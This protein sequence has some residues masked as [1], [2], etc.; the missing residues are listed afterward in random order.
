MHEHLA[1]A[2]LEM[3]FFV[4]RKSFKYVDTLFRQLVSPISRLSYPYEDDWRPP[5]L[6]LF[7]QTVP[8]FC[9]RRAGGTLDVSLLS[10][11]MIKL[12]ALVFSVCLS[13]SFFG[14]VILPEKHPIIPI[15]VEKSLF[16]C[17]HEEKCISI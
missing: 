1:A 3:T 9:S 12:C 5:R 17:Y 10:M 14:P 6:K 11:L 16:L 2:P 13:S 4:W 8:F 7:Y 15:I